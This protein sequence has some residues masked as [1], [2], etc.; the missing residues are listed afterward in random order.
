MEYRNQMGPETRQRF[1]AAFAAAK[2][3][4]KEKEIDKQ[5]FEPKPR[6][7]DTRYAAPIGRSV[8]HSTP[9]RP[10]RFNYRNDNPRRE[11]PR[12]EA[13]GDP[14]NSNNDAPRRSPDSRELRPNDKF[15]RYCKNRE[16]EIDECRKYNNAKKNES[17]N[18]NGPSGC[19]DG[20][21]TD[22]TSKIRPVRPINVEEEE[23][24]DSDRESQS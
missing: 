20:T 2:A 15:C 14:R 24:N 23:E 7:R 3:I 12:R 17:G 4:A 22:E 1:T 5:R 11:F 13:P 16:H 10:D 18:G 19:R 21:R 8:A 9:L 6:E